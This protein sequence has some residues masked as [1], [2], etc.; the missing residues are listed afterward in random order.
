MLCGRICYAEKLG[1]SKCY[2]LDG[3]TNP[4]PQ[5]ELLSATTTTRWSSGVETYLRFLPPGLIHAL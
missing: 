4:D 2:A 5:R 1:K 3:V